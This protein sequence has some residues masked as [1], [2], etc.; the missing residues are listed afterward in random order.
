[1]K[2]ITE[3][4]ISVS[5]DGGLSWEPVPGA[6]YRSD[7]FYSQNDDGGACAERTAADLRS[8][9]PGEQFRITTCYR[10]VVS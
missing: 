2:R 7:R 8:Q 9:C 1:M 3:Y 6:V 4:R 10:W 5:R